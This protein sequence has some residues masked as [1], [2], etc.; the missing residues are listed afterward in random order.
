MMY[1]SHNLHF[2][3]AARAAQGRFEDAKKAADQ[4]AANVAPG[5][6]EMPMLEGFLQIPVMMLV[7]FNRWDDILK[8]PAPNPKMAISTAVWRYARG[9]AYAAARDVKNAVNEQMALSSLRKQL[10]AGASFGLNSA[11]NVLKVAGSVLDARIA[12]ASGDA[13]ASIEHWKKAVEAQDA[14]AYDE[15]AGWYYP[16]RESLGAALLK[17]G[18]AAEAETVFREDLKRNSRS[19]R[20]LFGL[21]ESLKAQNKTSDV[22]WVRKQFEIAWKDST[23]PLQI[24]DL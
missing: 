20:S 1:Y 16:V 7:R 3:A 21:L 5:V 6:G 24:S 12:A 10:P 23:V 11:E 8:L 9:C 4:L 14:L 18:K 22:E 2:L 13:A 19:G 15:P 17:A